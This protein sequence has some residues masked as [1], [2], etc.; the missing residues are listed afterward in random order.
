MSKH[1]SELL[2]EKTL[3]DPRTHYTMGIVPTWS[4]GHKN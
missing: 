3:F 1:H 4:V 2:N